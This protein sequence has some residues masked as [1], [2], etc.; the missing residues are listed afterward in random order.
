MSD[1]LLDTPAPVTALGGASRHGV[2]TVTELP[3]RGMIT[4]RGDMA[5]PMMRNAATGLAG[6]DM[7][8]QRGIAIEGE[9][10]I[11]WMSPDELLV[12]LPYAEVASAM[13]TLDTNL[14]D[15]LVSAVDVSHARTILSVTGDDI[16]VRETVAKVCPV[17]MA[18]GRFGPG[19]IRRTRLSQ[20]PAALWMPAP[21]EVQV[22]CF[23]SVA[24]YALEVLA[25]S[26]LPGGEVGIF[27]P[28]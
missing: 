20:I 13:S 28:A 27:H 26:A 23:R 1:K 3:M 5:A 9:R 11:A 10:A 15:Q 2:V 21:G 19:E 7:P 24:A 6:V 8:V 18:P 22:I 16:A 17:D 4:I 14:A 25:L 12:L